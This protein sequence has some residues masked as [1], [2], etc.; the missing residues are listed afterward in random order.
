MRKLRNLGVTFKV[1]IAVGL[2]TLLLFVSILTLGY[3]YSYKQ[4]EEAAGIELVGCANITLGLQDPKAILDLK[5]G[6]TALTEETESNLNYIIQQKA[7][8]HTAYII[9]PSGELLATSESMKE[10]GYKTG[11]TYYIDEEAVK[12]ME[13][14]QHPEYSSV[15]EYNGESRQTGYSPIIVDGE[16]VAYNAIDFKGSVIS[17][18]TWDTVK[19]FLLVMGI[20]MFIG[21]VIILVLVHFL[22]RPVK[23]LS[24]IAH[25]IAEGDLSGESIQVK[26]RDEVGQLAESINMMNDNLKALIHN[27]SSATDSVSDKSKQLKTAISEVREGSEQI[28]ST[29]EELTH[30]SEA[31]A[32]SAGSLSETM[33]DFSLKI[34]NANLDGNEVAK[35]SDQVLQM[36]KEGSQYMQQSVD[37]MKRIDHIVNESIEK[38]K[39]LDRQ[40]QEISKLVQVIH[41]IAEQTNLLSLNA[42]IEAARA[43]EHGKGFAVVAGEVRK[44]S[45]QVAASVKDITQIVNMIQTESGSVVQ[46][47]TNGYQE[48]EKGTKQ[49][50]VTDETF[51]KINRAVTDMASK[52]HDI[53]SSLKGIANN[54]NEMNQS[55]EEIASVS[56]ESAAGVQQ[57]AASVQQSH[58]FIDEITINT[59]E[60]DSLADDLNDKMKKF[61]I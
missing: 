48:V 4:V 7:I 51:E 57:V 8:F 45:E 12:M 20:P 18:R 11:D 44:L 39:G 22:I 35:T 27:V 47:L 31:Q 17:D 24:K 54:S 10:F 3:Q 56:E 52:I 37:Q 21:M 29:M 32:N 14:M 61:K 41:D 38:V 49:I 34:Q 58:S 40:S 23:Q 28:S 59:N 25:K 46:S 13:D 1:A 15:Y 30:G 2:V 19:G 6:N 43:G 5:N 26:S 33:E 60:L 50:E 9:A 36:T 42:A 16:I 55:I 53:S